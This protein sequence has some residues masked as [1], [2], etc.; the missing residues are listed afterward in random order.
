MYV[1]KKPET[2]IPDFGGKDQI[3]KKLCSG[4]WVVTCTYGEILLGEDSRAQ[5]VLNDL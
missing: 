5:R 4:M 1:Q 3:L 2:D